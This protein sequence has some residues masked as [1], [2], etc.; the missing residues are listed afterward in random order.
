MEMKVYRMNRRGD[1]FKASQG[2]GLQQVVGLRSFF[3]QDAVGVL[4]VYA[5]S[6]RDLPS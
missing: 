4:K 3:L 6:E 1:R 5:G 2:G